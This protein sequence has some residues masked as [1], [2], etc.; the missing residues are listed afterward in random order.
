MTQIKQ[1]NADFYTAQILFI[2]V[3]C[4]LQREA[5]KPEPTASKKLTD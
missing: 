2:C 3:I 4:V 5:G 1:I